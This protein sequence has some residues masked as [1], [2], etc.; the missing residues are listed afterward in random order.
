MV[1]GLGL[2]DCSLPRS[3]ILFLTGDDR[4]RPPN[5][6]HLEAGERVTEGDRHGERRGRIAALS[7]SQSALLLVLCLSRSALDSMW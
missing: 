2:R 5:L 1:H 6:R 7:I 4:A 3:C